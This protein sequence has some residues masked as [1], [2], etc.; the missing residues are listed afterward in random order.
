MY[1][2]EELKP[3]N[4]TIIN[5][6][7][8]PYVNR[9]IINHLQDDRDMQYQLKDTKDPQTNRPIDVETRTRKQKTKTTSSGS[10]R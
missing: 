6:N 8:N 9:S 2:D 1:L 7:S 3:H 10:C 4:M 5:M